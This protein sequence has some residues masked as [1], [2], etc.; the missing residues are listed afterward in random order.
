MV[1]AGCSQIPDP[2]EMSM[3]PPDDRAETAYRILQTATTT[4]EYKVAF[5]EISDQTR[6]EMIQT[7]VENLLSQIDESQTPPADAWM[8][9]DMYRIT[10]RWKEA[11]VLFE[12][13]VRFAATK[14]RKVNDTLRLAQA[15]ARNGKPKLAIETARK[16]FG[17]EKDQTAPILPATLYEITPAAEGKGED[18]ALASLLEDAVKIH[19]E[20]EVD[21]ASEAGKAFIVARKYHIARAEKKIAELRAQ[22]SI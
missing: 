7:T 8:L 20:T 17:V 22:S 16:V 14:D 13:A 3:V 15:Q 1:L 4:L 19:E 12:K 21:K 10:N 5:K 18:R 6:N 2:N 11:E 9:A